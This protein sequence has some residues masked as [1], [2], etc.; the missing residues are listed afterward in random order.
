MKTTNKFIALTLALAA[1]PV[2]ASGQLLVTEHQS[3]GAGRVY[4]LDFM[5]DGKVTALQFD[6]E[7]PGVD[8]GSFNLKSCGGG[9]KKF[10]LD[11]SCNVVEGK[12]RVV[13]YSSELRS[14]PE[15]WHNLGEV[16]TSAAPKGQAVATNLIAGD[17]AGASISLEMKS[18]NLD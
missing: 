14:L 2:F 17:A 4:A 6:L 10:G 8:S 7:I 1:A 3:K 15:G 11:L 9:L 5:S 13:G 16:R 18:A 12:V